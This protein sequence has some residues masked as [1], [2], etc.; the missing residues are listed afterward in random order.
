MSEINRA[1]LILELEEHFGKPVFLLV[2]NYL[3]TSGKS[4]IESGDEFYFRQFRENVIGSKLL[5]C[6]LILNGPGGNTKTAIA[7]SQIIRDSVLRYDSFV[8]TVAGSSLCYFILK[9]NKLLLGEK[10]LITQIDTLFNYE[11]KEL[12][13]IEHLNDPNKEIKKLAHD[14][15]NPALENL[16]EILKNKPHVFEDDVSQ[17][18]KSRYTFLEKLIDI[19]MKKTEHDKPLTLNDI[20]SLKIRYKL[21]P[22]EIINKTKILITECLNELIKENKRFVIQTSKIED[23]KY[24]GGYFFG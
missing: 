21:E 17:Q 10:S 13:A 9:S 7:C 4:F 19:W 24:L 23:D 12:R 8:P 20:K 2:Y 3:D 15:H 18:S 22:E 5:D 1:K 16:K 14:A 11:G 6:V